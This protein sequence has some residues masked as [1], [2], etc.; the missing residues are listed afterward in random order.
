MPKRTK[1]VAYQRGEFWLDFD[2]APDGK[3]RRPSYYIFRYDPVRGRTVSTSTGTADLD[4]ARTALDAAFLKANGGKPICQSCGQTLPSHHGKLLADAIADYLVTV[5]PERS[6]EEAIRSRLAHVVEYIASLPNPAVTCAMVDETWVEGLRKHLRAKPIL[7]SRKDG[8][9]SSRPRSA[10]TIENSVL[11][12]QAALHHAMGEMPKFKVKPA[13]QVNQSPMFRATEADLM[14]MFQWCMEQGARADALRRF[15]VL[16]VA[17]VA[18]PDAVME[19]SVAPER[20]QWI[21]QHRVIAL[22]PKGRTQTRKFRPHVKCPRQLV[23]WLNAEKGQFVRS[24]D[25]AVGSVR[26]AWR[27]MTK[28]L[29]L[30]VHGQKDIRRS[31]AVILRGCGVPGPEVEM[32]LGH[33]QMSASSQVYAPFSPA[34]LA[35]AC[36]TIEDLIDRIEAAVPGAFQP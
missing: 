2:R 17:T 32:Q 1:K 35:A 29:K 31:T 8:T 6:S 28:A 11:Q 34:Y 12:L 3:P 15:L 5:A 22:N 9:I 21:A 24:K 27:S 14:A 36:S 20:G 25:G 26:T 23:D 10:S 13:S 33:R 18:R 7:T 16:S 4:A 30:P 19:F